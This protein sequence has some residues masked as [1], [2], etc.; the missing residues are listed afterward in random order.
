MFP[1]REKDGA[2]CWV[3]DI[4]AEVWRASGHIARY[5]PIRSSVLSRPFVVP[6]EGARKRQ[7]SR[8]LAVARV[9]RRI[10]D[11]DRGALRGQ[12]RDVHAV[13]AVEKLPITR[14]TLG[15]GAIRKSIRA[16]LRSP[17]A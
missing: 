7:L 4:D 16:G 15:R 3:Y 5:T 6:E 14:R 12:R 10:G 1:P 8:Y 17:S 13:E 11:D 2:G 9:H